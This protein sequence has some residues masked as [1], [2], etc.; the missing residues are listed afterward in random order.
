MLI[1][2]LMM[3]AGSLVW[4]AAWLRTI[5]QEVPRSNVDFGWLEG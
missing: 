4:T 2:L 1:A 5:W 3:L